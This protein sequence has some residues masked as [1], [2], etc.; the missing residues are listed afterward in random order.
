M[1]SSEFNFITKDVFILYFK[2]YFIY[3]LIPQN[4][5]QTC[6]QIFSCH[7]IVIYHINSLCFVH[8]SKTPTKYSFSEYNA[9]RDNPGYVAQVMRE[10]RPLGHLLHKVTLLRPGEVADLPKTQTQTNGVSKNKETNR[11]Q[12]KER[13]KKP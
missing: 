8:F 12:M 2:L 11:S 7:R 1:V 3:Q 13:D 10:T 9:H 5:R 6:K 4:Y